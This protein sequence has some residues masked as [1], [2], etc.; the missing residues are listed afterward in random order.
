MEKNLRSS[1][2]SSPQEFITLATKL[3]LKSSKP[4]LK[5]L[6]HSIKPS[7]DLIS[8]LPKT[9]SDSIDS[10][11][12]SFMN[13][14]N[15]DSENPK[16]PP[17]TTLR[18]S[19][20][21]NNTETK[22]QPDKKHK[23]LERLQIL[24]HISFLCFSHPRKVFNLSE[25]FPGVQ[26]LHDHLKW[27]ESDSVLCSGI[28]TICEE[29][30]KENLP[31]RE[32]LIA[33]T[34]SFLL[35]RSLDLMKK[36]DVHRVYM[37]REAFTWF[38]FEDESTESLKRLLNL[39]VVSPLYLKTE[40]GRKFLSFLF[41]LNDQLEKE[42]LAMIR[43][44]I[45]LG[46]KSILEAFGDILFR[47]WKASPED[48][49]SGIENGFLQDLIEGSIHAS[50]GAFASHIRTVLGAFINQRTVDGVEKLLY[51][52]A[53]PV[54]FRSL[55]A[56]NSNVRQNALHLLL[57][58]FPL[59]D[60]D[61]TKEDKDTLLGKQFFLLERLLV[62]DCP[63]VRTIAIEGSCR[64]LHLFWEVIP[65]PI[66]TKMLTKIIG[67]MSHDA[68]NDV[69]LSTLNGIIYLLDN[70]H[71][72]E[73]L[74]V[75]CPRLGH[76]MQD[77]VLTVRVAVAD[78]LL[79]LNDV[80]NF[81]FNK[82]VNLDLLLSVL[83]SDQP[84]VAQKI[85]KLLIPSYFPSTVPIEEACNRC[86]RLVK[87]APMAGAIFCKYAVLEGASKTH[88]IELVKVF[89][90]L[91]LS[92]DQLD[93]GQ[94]EGFL[95]AAS[96]LCDNLA[97]E[98]CYMNA[99]KD[100]LT[101]EKVQGLLTGASTEQAQSSLFNIFST[102][103]PDSVT[104]LLEECMT[105][106]TNCRGLPED[107][108]RQSKMRSA[109]KLLLSL[110][111]FDDMFETLTTILHKAAYRS[112]IKFGADMPSHSLTAMKIKKSKS[113]GK[114]SIQSKIINRKQSFEDDYLVAVGVAWQV[115]DL[116]QHEDTR[117]AIFKSQP[118][119]MLFFSLKMVSEVSIV[120]CGQYEYIDISPVLAYMALALQMTVDNVGTSSENK[121]DSKRKKRKT[122]LDLTIEHV[123]NC[124]EKL[125]GLDDTVQ[126]RS[127]DSCNS[128]STTGKKNSRKRRRLSLTS[129]GCPSNGGSVQNKLQHVLCKVK[130]L[131]AVL[132]FMAD[133]TA[134]CFS[135]HNNGL[136][137]NYT[138]KCIQHILS[139]LNQ[140]CHNKTQFEEEDKKNTI[141][142][143]K[144]SFTYAAKILNV[145]LP[146]SGESSI[147]TSQAFT[148]ANNLLDLIVSIESCLGSAYASRLVAAARPW[149]PDVV[150]ALG[151]P[152]VLQQTDS[153]SE[154]STASE[155]IKLN[156]PKWPLVLAKTVLLSAVNEDEGDHECSQPDKYSAFN[157]L[158]DMLI[159]ILK[160]NR[161]IMDAIGDIFLV[162]SLVGLE[163]KDFDLALGLLQFVCSKLF[164][165]DDRDWGDMMLST[166][167]EI[168]P[169]IERGRTE[170]RNDDELE[171][172]T[173]AKNLIE[174]LWTYHLFESGKVNMTDD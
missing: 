106:V 17:T 164:N 120:H 148:L 53:E 42:L 170:P 115:R 132:K 46:R 34:V 85:T 142:C 97:C 129:A 109:H 30:W 173:H 62:D 74:K 83:A 166:L 20:R 68:C 18:R 32:N 51:R 69:R 119:E 110:G 40:D 58:I 171:K 152:S 122:V 37:L 172:L 75:L 27:L 65:S 44:Q 94:I 139:S 55:Q 14:L 8:S 26:A 10:T 72:H 22:P 81:Q 123:L 131:T 41:R 144:S 174:P 130:M 38:D 163:Q 88:L 112:H 102:V 79:R 12:K 35:S 146:D 47:A 160:K 116:L 155:Q 36:V 76:L 87:R 159:I 111:G 165:H 39:C 67:D 31:D 99:L 89:L 5:T 52:L 3:T 158:L 101:A 54:I 29:W 15:S 124:L 107:V 23:L 98:P 19:S 82:V 149:L 63:E 4:I 48:S 16:T 49:R 1:L 128:R 80:I 92:P 77:N 118:L 154:H 66:I 145:T 100:L 137:L 93:A 45:K 28:V 161:S 153:G 2:Q 138:S 134:M 60:P 73:V 25:L 9:L 140:L 114:F 90:S 104:G 150:L 21:K 6:I 78:L 143:L 136:F 43:S 11:I 162:C 117:K 13:L 86:I 113:S 156:F 71:S 24:S 168:Y 7:S 151:S 84:P 61:A 59:E 96:F 50:S 105:V 127:V 135:P 70:P 57:D 167:Q 95:V 33:Q 147:T 141:F 121:G 91:V 64:V 169:K 108:D 126:N 56:A 125:F 133:T 103:C 157:K